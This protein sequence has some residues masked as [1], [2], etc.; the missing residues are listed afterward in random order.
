MRVTENILI[1]NPQSLAGRGFCRSFE[2]TKIQ[3]TMTNLQPPCEVFK[4][5]IEFEGL[6]EISNYGRVKSLER[7]VLKKNGRFIVNTY[8][9]EKILVPIP[10]QGYHRVAL[11]K[12]GIRYHKNI[13]TLVAIAF[14]ENETPDIRD[15]I[16]HIDGDKSN[17]IIS[18]LEWCSRSENT[19]HAY[20]VLGR[21]RA[22]LGEKNENCKWSKPVIQ[23]TKEGEII[24]K[25]SS[26]SETKEYGFDIGCVSSCCNG[27]L[28]TYKGFIWKRFLK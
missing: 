8:Y 15:Q 7:R 22:W 9:N 18:N 11:H 6:Y 28:K 26:M 27:R 2:S 14:I 25:Y 20:R 10:R 23:L 4:P 3:T 19:L 17:N 13:H 16:N 24:R 21:K 5:I 12:N 1:N